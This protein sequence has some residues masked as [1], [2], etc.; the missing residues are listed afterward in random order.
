VGFR[1]D[2]ADLGCR[3][4]L[5]QIQRTI[6]CAKLAREKQLPGAP[7]DCFVEAYEHCLVL[8]FE[9]DGISLIEH[10]KKR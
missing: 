6:N 2:L 10:Q 5:E 8:C 7:R 9:A 4:A 1:F 3:K